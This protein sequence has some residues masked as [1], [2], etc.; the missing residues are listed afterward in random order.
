VVALL[1]ELGWKA[2]RSENSQGRL[3]ACAIV[4]EALAATEEPLSEAAVAKI[5][6]QHRRVIQVIRPPS[7]ERIRTYLVI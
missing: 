7:L 2:T 4:A 5:W 3:S 6:H 1:L